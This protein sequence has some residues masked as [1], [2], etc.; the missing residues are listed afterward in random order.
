ME[1]NITNPT[2][3]RALILLFPPVAERVSDRYAN[4]FSVAHFDE[5]VRPFKQATREVLSRLAAQWQCD[6][7]EIEL[8]YPVEKTLGEFVS[9]CAFIVCLC[10]A[11]FDRISKQSMLGE[12]SFAKGP[13]N[14]CN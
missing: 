12:K 1:L 13:L 5:I 3:F 11:I 6:P 14:Y 9:A 7:M 8:E 2:L 4:D 10:H